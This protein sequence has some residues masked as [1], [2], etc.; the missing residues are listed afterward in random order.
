MSDETKLTDNQAEAFHLCGAGQK[1]FTKEEGNDRFD[2]TVWQ[3][4]SQQQPLFFRI[5]T[6]SLHWHNA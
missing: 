3:E 6:G 5:E 2:R 1:T 4:R